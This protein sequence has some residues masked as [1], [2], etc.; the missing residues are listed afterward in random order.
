MLLD[1]A[2]WAKRSS[3]KAIIA[4]SWACSVSHDFKSGKHDKQA[5]LSLLRYHLLI[6]ICLFIWFIGAKFQRNKPFLRILD[7]QCWQYDT[8]CIFYCFT[9][10][11]TVSARCK[12]LLYI[13]ACTVH[14]NCSRNLSKRFS[15]KYLAAVH[16]F[17]TFE[18]DKYKCVFLITVSMGTL[19]ILSCG[20]NLVTER[21]QESIN[22]YDT[23]SWEKG[24]FS[25]LSPQTR[26]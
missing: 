19:K 1:W 25:S 12:S 4:T 26:V 7:C 6:H 15:I 16:I 14:W 11:K 20:Y 3:G 21:K 18:H 13:R 17:C 8:I 9:H 22:C 10:G 5:S 23:R 2:P 24:S